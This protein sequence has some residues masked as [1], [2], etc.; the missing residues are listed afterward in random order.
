[1]NG[2][3]I[4]E[5]DRRFSIS[6]NIGVAR[7]NHVIDSTSSLIAK[8]DKALYESRLNGRNTVFVSTYLI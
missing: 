7:F 3:E 5:Q 4:G 1:M 6:C 8:V 2:L